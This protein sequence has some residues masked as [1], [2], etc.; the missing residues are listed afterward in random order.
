M[1]LLKLYRAFFRFNLMADMAYRSTF[2]FGVFLTCVESL[3][4]FISI[5]VLFRHVNSIAGWSYEHMLIL[6][7]TFIL[8]NAAAWL[9]FRAGISDLDRVINKGDL[10]WYLVKPIDT[11]L[12][13]TIQR[14]DIEDAGRSLVGLALLIFGLRDSPTIE[15]LTR[16]PVFFIL[17]GSGQIVLYSIQLI[18]KSVSFKSIQ[19][20]ATNSIAWRF[21]ELAQ[22]PTDIYRSLLRVVY[23][24]IFPLAFIVTVPAK[25][26][27]GKLTVALFFGSILAALVTFTAARLIWKR[28]LRSYSSA[29]S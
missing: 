22:F 6:L 29:S 11:Q 19:G 28:A 1:R 5:T 7:G 21:H 24:F 17:F 9:L 25:A 27:T 26:L 15:I 10:D 20:W 12:L 3:A 4:V 13:V 18:F 2:L 14:I 16:L 23:T 8:S